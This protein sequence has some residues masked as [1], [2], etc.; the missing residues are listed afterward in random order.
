M[1]IEYYKK[2]S[3]QKRPKLLTDKSKDVYDKLEK[4]YDE[5]CNLE[6]IQTIEEILHVNIYMV[7]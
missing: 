2:I 3:N 6:D 4:S 5:P 7:S 1:N